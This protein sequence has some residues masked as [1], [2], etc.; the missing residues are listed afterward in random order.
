[1]ALLF[2]QDLAPLVWS[3]LIYVIIE[4]VGIQVVGVAP[5]DKIRLVVGIIARTTVHGK[6]DIKPFDLVSP[7]LGIKGESVILS[8]AHG[9]YLASGFVHAKEHSSDL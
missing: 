9:K 6:L 5:P 7:L 2:I 1:M 3:V 8:M 4:P